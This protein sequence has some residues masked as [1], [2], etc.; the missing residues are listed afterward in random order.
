MTLSAGNRLG[1]YEIVS[2]LGAGGM[3]EVYRARDTKLGREVAVKVLPEAFACD[4]ERIARFER[5]AKVLASLNHPHIAALYGMEQVEGQHVLILEL[6]EGET[7]AERLR[8]GALPIEQALT[9][10]IQIA[11]G[12]EAAHEKGIVHRDL[13]PA[14]IKI[15]PDEQ[16]KVLD[17]G[18][19][20][21]FGPAEAKPQPDLTASP[22][23]SLMATQAG[24]ILGTA[25]YMSPEQ[26]KGAPADHRSDV[27]AFG[28]VLYEMLTGRQAFQGDS[29]PE[30]LASVLARDP[31]FAALPA[32]LHPRLVDLLRRCLDKHPKRRWQAVGD[33]RVEFE[34]IASALHAVPVA[35][36]LRGGLPMWRRLALVGAPAL[37]LGAAMAS[38]AV[39]FATRP[40]LPRVTRLTITP[41]PTAPLSVNSID[42]DL[43]ITSDGSRVIYVGAN[44]T[45]LFAR[46]L[47]R[48]EPVLVFKGAPRGP[49]TSPDSQWVGFVDGTTSLKK[50]AL[51]GGPPVTI[52]V[53][54]GTGRGAAWMQDDQIVFATSAATTGLQR[55]SAAG[56]MPVVL[57]RPDRG[58]GE[59]DHVWPESLPDGRGILFT[60]TAV[61]GA[62][63]AAQIALLDLRTRTWK[64]VARGGTHAHYVS[65]GHLIYVAGG[66]LWAVAFDLERLETFGGAVPIV[67]DV[68]TSPFGALDAAVSADG[69]LAYVTGVATTGAQR[70]L[71]WVD[72]QGRE[73]PLEAPPRPYIYP[74]LAPDGTRVSVFLQ[75][76]ELDIW[77][78]DFVR[79]TFSRATF[80][81]SL[82]AQ[83]AWTPDGRRLIF[84]S[85]RAGGRNL[86]AQAVDG[87]GMVERV[88]ES[89]NEQNM[90]AVSPDGKLMIYGE[91]RP[92]T[93]VDIM[94]TPLDGT[95]V[96]LPL[97]QTGFSEQNGIVSPDNRWLAYEANESG[98][99]EVY[100]R[101]FPDVDRGRWQVSTGGGTRPLW[102]RNG[103]ELFYVSASGAIMG[104][105]VEQGPAWVAGTPSVV[106]KEGYLTTPA[107]NVGRTYDISSDG[108]RFLVVKSAAGSSQTAEPPRLVVVQG[109][110]EELKARVPAP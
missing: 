75:D 28:C 93:G 99:F 50:I 34:T 17:F 110:N 8:R 53:M 60:V 39:W 46:A 16:V 58:R 24:M 12:L 73:I 52:A 55:V 81:P 22:T 77:L 70:R 15:T 102:A 1:P 80:D 3:G 62:V 56:G 98:Q 45:Q 51:T 67:S 14:N 86:Y 97:V 66:T 78:W 23:L 91:T 89:S 64:V 4:S 6:V 90:T 71:A 82:D 68:V 30:I 29:A 19:A 72:R 47:D 106:V 109:W 104:V 44:G 59:A 48:L 92:T 88:T 74:R 25:A 11:D 87:T 94:Q 61:G 10:A 85:E 54:D 20:K 69:V 42:R 108:Q 95:R 103:R 26:A 13:K 2:P 33:L 43:A 5:E 107:G 7:L 49:F 35:V 63:D 96:A 40:A 83:H 100:V 37:L 101:P 32:N 36:V 31:D 79:K 27:F 105:A 38:G 9:L 21:A 76:Q 18:L 65:S 57:T 84:S 41:P